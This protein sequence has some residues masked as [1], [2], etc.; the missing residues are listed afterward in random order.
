MAT[1]IKNAT[2]N[3]I[4]LGAKD[5]SSGSNPFEL[6]SYPY[7]VPLFFIFAEKGPEEKMIISS[8]DITTIYGDKTLDATE[9]YYNHQT[10]F[11]N[12]A[13]TDN[14]AVAI[15][16]II[17]TNAGVKANIALYI[18]IAEQD[19]PNYLRN[20]DGS[21]V[22]DD[23]TNSYKV[24]TGKATIEGYKIRFIAKYNAVDKDP[25]FGNLQPIG[26]TM[27][28]KDGTASTMYP[29]FETKASNF[30]AYYNNVGFIID[31]FDSDDVDEDL[32]NE[33]VMPFKIKVVTRE[34]ANTSYVVQS[35]LNGE[36]Y[37]TVTLTS[38]LLHPST[39]KLTNIEYRFNKGW[40]NTD[41]SIGDYVYPELDGC[42]FYESNYNNILMKLYLKE[43]KYVFSTKCAYDK[44]NDRTEG[45][46]EIH[47]EWGD[48]G[49]VATST[50]YD[51]TST[52]ADEM[53]EEYRFMNP[54]T[55]STLKGVRYRSVIPY[56]GT[57]VVD[58]QYSK[59]VN[60]LNASPVWLEGGA[61]GSMTNTQFENKVQT[62]MQKYGKSTS[63]VMDLA[64][65]L[66]SVIYDSGFSLTTKK[67]LV[68][69]IAQRKDTFLVLST[70]DAALGKNYAS[71]DKTK[72]I[73]SALRSRLLMAKESKYY[74][75]SVARAV[76]VV[77]TGLLNDIETEDRIP[78]TYELMMKTSKL[79]GSKDGYWN[80][81][82]LFDKVSGNSNGGSLINY[83][84]D[85]Q[86]ANLTQNTKNQLWSTGL[87]WS[88][89]YDLSSYHFPGI[90]TIYDDDTSVL[91]SYLAILAL[92][93]CTKI[94][95]EVYR[96]FVG[97]STLSNS[98]FKRQ[99]QEALSN[100]LKNRFSTYV[101][102]TP[103]VEITDDDAQRGYSWR[104]HISITAPTMK[105]VCV[106]TT[107]FSRVEE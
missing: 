9:P 36:Q 40:Y 57:A 96:N 72:A 15:K 2:P 30:G 7:H 6:S 88:Q 34:D 52:D 12:G 92:S 32:L 54:F 16:R 48:G 45:G 23:E 95:A 35:T 73:G 76:I 46:V 64:T 11:L 101:V 25:S 44:V 19:I 93:T 20:S 70:H 42:Y 43:K 1:I 41:S 69:F 33:K 21:Y 105:T 3:F 77:G 91:N 74:G 103:S 81:S 58:D 22:V 28:N 17:P 50:W 102:A 94:A 99:N 87:I 63:D 56:D 47:T 31:T 100:R 83:L 4:A 106:Y 62:F 51:F 59:E 65:N 29:I 90:Q 75:T 84:T 55:C 38:K 26:G 80:T 71:I 79:A 107:E 89:P 104:T 85:L 39:N 86:P 18:D 49:T 68:N 10:R 82:A 67:T 8:G 37:E 5:S 98:E 14:Y 27:T 78:Q 61:D 24:V 53:L 13:L 60:M 97:S 66:E